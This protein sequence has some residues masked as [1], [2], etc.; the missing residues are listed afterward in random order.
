M[1]ATTEASNKES[2]TNA[3]RQYSP[4]IYMKFDS[5]GILDIEDVK[6]R[7]CEIECDGTWGEG[8]KRWE[9]NSD[10]SG[11]VS[12]LLYEDGR[13]EIS[14]YRIETKCFIKHSQIHAF[15]NFVADFGK[16]ITADFPGLHF[17]LRPVFVSAAF[18]FSSHPK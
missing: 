16:K 4:S 1:S 10:T 8:R 18:V 15:E 17:A 2:L 7:F 13:R 6:R 11:S 9:W 12:Y 14:S 3:L 5:P